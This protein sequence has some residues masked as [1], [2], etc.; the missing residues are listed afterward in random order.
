MALESKNK[1]DPA[2]SLSSMTDVIFL[3]LIFFMLTSSAVTPTGVPV[4]T[5]TSK[6]VKIEM[7]KVAV[8]ITK[9]LQFFVNGQPVGDME[10][11]EMRLQQLLSTQPEGEGVV[12]LHVDKEVPTQYLVEVAGTAN[13]LK[14][15]VSIAAKPK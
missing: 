8:T 13:S 2:F 15:R 3:L 9:D 7:Q 14:A 11:V 4:S 10:G 1:V 12:V 6:S 5:P